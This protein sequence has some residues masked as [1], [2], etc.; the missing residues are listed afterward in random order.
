MNSKKPTVSAS[1]I[2]KSGIHPVIFKNRGIKIY[3]KTYD[4]YLDFNDFFLV[5]MIDD[6][7]KLIK[8]GSEYL[9]YIIIEGRK[10]E[11][12]VIKWSDAQYVLEQIISQ[13]ENLTQRNTCIELRNF[14]LSKLKEIKDFDSYNRVINTVA[15]RVE[16]T[17]LPLKQEDDSIIDFANNPNIHTVNYKDNMVILYQYKFNVYCF[18]VSLQNICEVKQKKVHLNKYC[19]APKEFTVIH[20]GGTNKKVKTQLLNWDDTQQYVVNSKMNPVEKKNFLNFLGVEFN[21]VNKYGVHKVTVDL[22]KINTEIQEIIEKDILDEGI[23]GIRVNDYVVKMFEEDGEQWFCCVDIREAFNI[24]HLHYSYRHLCSETR[25]RKCNHLNPSGKKSKREL[26]FTNRRGCLEMAEEDPCDRAYEKME[27][28]LSKIPAPEKVEKAEEEKINEI[29]PDKQTI[30][31]DINVWNDLISHVNNHT[32]QCNASVVKAE[33]QIEIPERNE[34]ME[35]MG[36][37]NYIQVWFD[38]SWWGVPLDVPS[39]EIDDKVIRCL[40]AA[41]EAK[42]SQKKE[43]KRKAESDKII[44]E[45]TLKERRLLTELNSVKAKKIAMFPTTSLSTVASM[46]VNC[47]IQ[48]VTKAMKDDGYLY[49]D[50]AKHCWD[51]VADKKYLNLGEAE[52]KYDKDNDNHYYMFLMTDSGVSLALDCLYKRGFEID[53]SR[54][55]PVYDQLLE[56][57]K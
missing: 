48:D 47:R 45:L 4:C 11:I 18:V 8:N 21:R 19:E 54:L 50:E 20:Y 40:K 22:S 53:E 17:F 33:N 36:I 28:W 24:R 46:F 5:S 1:H 6:P 16:D 41:L 29:V 35:N 31:V 52:A 56:R 9:S 32:S 39:Y 44:R 15:P 3:K 30:T 7:K 26:F 42:N 34:Y 38:G 57:D 49:F 23:I 12:P 13:T 2:Q 27:S 51:V 43:V 55:N 37:N 14:L 25:K 10:T